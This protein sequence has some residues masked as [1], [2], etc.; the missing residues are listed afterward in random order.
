MSDLER[1][2]FLHAKHEREGVI[3]EVNTIGLAAFDPAE[4]CAFCS[5]T[6][7]K[8]SSCQGI[9]WRGAPGCRAGPP[10]GDAKIVRVT[11]Q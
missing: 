10:P 5:G 2:R 4:H 9:V 3:A 7:C 6:G 11:L 1:R 8:C